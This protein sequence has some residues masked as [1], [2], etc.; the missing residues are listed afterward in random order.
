MSFAM[1]F[2]ATPRSDKEII[3]WGILGTVLALMVTL[4]QV[5]YVYSSWYTYSKPW[6]YVA[7]AAHLAIGLWATHAAFVMGVSTWVLRR[8]LMREE[9]VHEIY[10]WLG[11][12]LTVDGASLAELSQ[13]GMNESM[14]NCRGYCCTE[15]GCG[16]PVDKSQVVP[17]VKRKELWTQ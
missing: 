9:I 5:L 8:M 3:N 7:A 1:R 13:G 14:S 16:C 12:P 6:C 4:Q 11:V 2:L 10:D 15:E 17:T